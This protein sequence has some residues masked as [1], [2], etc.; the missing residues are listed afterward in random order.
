MPESPENS[1]VGRKWTIWG[2]SAK[3]IQVRVIAGTY[4]AH[5]AMIAIAGASKVFSA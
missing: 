1:P 2:I 3:L 5:S 4:V